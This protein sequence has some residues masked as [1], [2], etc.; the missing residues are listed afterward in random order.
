M[1][2]ACDEN[3]FSMPGLSDMNNNLGNH[4]YAEDQ[5][6]QY[7]NDGGGNH[8]VDLW[9]PHNVLLPNSLKRDNDES[10]DI[11]HGI[12]K[13]AKPNGA[14]YGGMQQGMAQRSFSMGIDNNNVF[15]S[16]AGYLL[17]AKS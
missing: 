4:L 12:G 10:L 7:Q 16:S 1:H 11:Q 9:R 14:D 2:L 3:I 17:S 8:T 5:D 13:R 6:E 15:V